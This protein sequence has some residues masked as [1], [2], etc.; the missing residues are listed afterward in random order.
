MGH[1]KYRE[2]VEKHK[3]KILEVE[4]Y[5]WKHPESGY[6]EWNTTKYLAGIFEEVKFIGVTKEFEDTNRGKV[7]AVN[8]LFHVPYY[9]V[10]F[11]I[12]SHLS[13]LN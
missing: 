13:T 5:I 11:H 3:D 2:L 9:N 7:K 8:F 1:L 12:R 10:C 4:R 6:R